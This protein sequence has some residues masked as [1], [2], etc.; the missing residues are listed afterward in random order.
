MKK[1]EKNPKIEEKKS[2]KEKETKKEAEFEEKEIISEEK[3]SQGRGIKIDHLVNLILKDKSKKDEIINKLMPFFSL[4]VIPQRE[5][6]RVYS[7]LEMI[8]PAK[9]RLIE[10]YIL[11]EKKY[12]EKNL[13]RTNSKSVGL[14]DYDL[15]L[16]LNILGHKQSV[17]YDSTDMK[18]NN[19]SINNSKSHCIHSIVVKLFRIVIDFK[20][21]KLARQ[22][23]EE[24]EEVKNSNATEK[25]ILLQKLVDKFGLYV[26]LELIVGGRINNSFDANSEEEIRQ[27]YSLLRKEIEIKLGGGCKFFSGSGEGK[28]GNKNSMEDLAKSIGK[29]ENL[30][31]K[32]EGGDF[33]CEEDYQKWIQSFTIDNLQ[34]IEYKTLTSIYSFIPGLESKLSICLEKYE[35]IA[36]KEIYNLMETNFIQKEKEIFKGSSENMNK[37]KVGITSEKYKSCIIYRKKIIKN[38]KNK[39][40][41]NKSVIC[42]EIPD[43]FVICG[44]ILK[45]NA[46]SKPFDVQANWERKKEIP[47]IG[48]ENFKFK[49]DL[50]VKKDINEN[51][52]IDW[53]L[54]IFCIHS[55]YLVQ[56][57]NKNNYP[58]KSQ[59]HYF[60]N[61]D[62]SQENCIY[63]NDNNQRNIPKS[64]QMMNSQF[65]NNKKCGY[66]NL[67]G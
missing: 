57:F 61:C 35:D 20:D 58:N 59:K 19:S 55:D 49:V 42:G 26:P 5:I 18:N 25:K 43:G 40:N 66:G 23:L 65:C 12:S 38:L 2:I 14:S 15:D 36:L 56:N 4:K 62:C 22:I 50:I 11:E 39:D 13:F 7:A 46:N 10:E 9:I 51:I 29:I 30:S 67:F 1:E 33:T 32:I 54:E 45:T 21:I 63:N 16:S 44:W 41:Q 8:E 64:N 31:K 47:I 3:L 60:I 37:W 27:N 34:I 52:E 28:Y 17:N 48:E 53:I 6:D 24:L